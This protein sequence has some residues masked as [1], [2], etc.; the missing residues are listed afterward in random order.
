MLD[1]VYRLEVSNIESSG[2]DQK[3]TN[4]TSFDYKIRQEN[5]ASQRAGGRYKPAAVLLW[6]FRRKKYRAVIASGNSDEVDEVEAFRSGDEIVVV[7]RNCGMGYVGAE[8]FPLK[9]DG[10][11]DEINPKR[12]TVTSSGDVFFQ[13]ASEEL[14]TDKWEDW[15]LRH[16]AKVLSGWLE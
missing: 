13:N 11:P 5:E 15:T 6:S 1:Y 3:G 9:S 16:V 14:E 12:V 4:M 8:V 2:L 7:S 10:S